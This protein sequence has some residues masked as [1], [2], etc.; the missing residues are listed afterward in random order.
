MAK[1]QQLAT[2]RSIGTRLE[3]A[4]SDVAGIEEELRVAI[5]QATQ[6]GFVAEVTAAEIR[7]QYGLTPRTG[8]QLV[9][10][11]AP[12][13][14]ERG[15]SEGAV[16]CLRRILRERGELADLVK[17]EPKEVVYCHPCS[18]AG[19]ADKPIYHA[20]PACPEVDH[21]PGDAQMDPPSDAETPPSDE[22]ASG[23]RA[24]A[25][26]DARGVL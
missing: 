17:E 20:P 19:G 1:S 16:D 22:T 18:E 10:L 21:S 25:A 24:A 2:I 5:D 15:E 9:E 8:D 12:F 13:A 7:V 4:R 23:A 3:R 11:L 6:S 14:G 26:E